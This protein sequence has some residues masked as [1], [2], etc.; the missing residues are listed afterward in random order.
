MCRL[1]SIGFGGL[2][3][4]ALALFAV[5]TLG[6][7]GQPAGPL[8]AVFLIPLGLPWIYMVDVLPD[9]VRPWAAAL[10]PLVNWLLI[11]LVCAAARTRRG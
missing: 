1:V 9:T 2:Y 7:F 4:L 10:A 5:G 6:L 11:G 8:A 3:A